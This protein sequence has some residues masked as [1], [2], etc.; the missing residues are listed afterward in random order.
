ME[1]VAKPTRVIKRYNN[2]KLYDCT[3]SCYVTLKE[4][5]D[6]VSRKE[7]IQVID[8]SSQMDITKKTMISLVLL[9]QEEEMNSQDLSS[10]ILQLQK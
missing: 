6:I 7:N 5:S 10:L 3:D 1:T 9:K 2:R 4:V 8:N